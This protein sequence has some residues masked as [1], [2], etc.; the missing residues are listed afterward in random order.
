[1]PNVSYTNKG[2]NGWTAGG[3][4]TAFRFTYFLLLLSAPLMAFYYIYI[5]Y[6]EIFVKMQR[7]LALLK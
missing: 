2:Y 7:P 5:C 3:I 1:M 4:L 6:Q